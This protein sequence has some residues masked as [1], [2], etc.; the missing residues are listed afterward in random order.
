MG[1]EHD[2]RRRFPVERLE[3]LDDVGA[4]VAVEIA[5][6]LVGEENPRLIGERPRD[7]D[8]LL[9]AARE[10]RRK[11][12]ETIAQPHPAQQLA[13]AIARAAFSAELQRHLHVFER[14]ECGDQLKALEHEADFLAAQLRALVFVHRREIGVV[15]D[16][17]AA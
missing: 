10:L 3:Q 16:H 8:A 4:R 13:R 12:I 2:R 7:G 17:R 9:L 1:D 6:R 11:V 14:R 5:R 15:E